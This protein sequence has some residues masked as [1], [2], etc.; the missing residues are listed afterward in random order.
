MDAE[1]L[2]QAELNTV[3][4]E[5]GGRGGLRALGPRALA[6]LFVG[7]SAGV[8]LAVLALRNLYDDELLTLYLSRS[9]V[10]EI[11][12]VAG[13]GDVHPP[14]MYL[15][16]HVGWLLT[17]S[18]RW[19]N[20]VPMAVL[21]AGLAVF[22]VSVAPLFRS[23]SERV[24]LLLLATLHPEL[25]MWSNTFRWYCPWTGLALIALTVAL[26][27][28]KESPVITPARA[29]LLGFLMGALFYLNYITLLFGL[30]LIAAALRRCRAGGRKVLARALAIAGAVFAALILPQLRT[31]LMVHLASGHA[32]HYGLA[33]SFVR[34]LQ[35][36]GESEAFLPWHPLA[37]AAFAALGALCVSGVAVLFRR[38][39]ASLSE[40][41]EERRSVAALAVFGIAYFV[42]LALAGLGGKPRSGLLLVPLLALIVA[43]ALERLGRR[44]HVSVL[45]LLGLWAIVGS[46]HLLGR[47]SALKT[48]M[49]DRPEEVVAFVTRS[50]REQPP[51]PS[52]ASTCGVVVVYDSGLAF[53]LAQ[54]TIPG[55]RIVSAFGGEIFTGSMEDRPEDCPR[56][57]LFV[58]ESYIDGVPMY[59][60]A[61]TRELHAA[62][63]F[64]RAPKI[65]RLNRDGDA[66]GK[67]RLAQ[68]L[69]S[70]S[71]A[72]LPDFRYVVVWGAMN[73]ASY[74]TMVDAL[75]DFHGVKR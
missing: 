71:G 15:L 54:A 12:G 14:G 25:L 63:S 9:S 22:L 28:G 43:A 69:R 47:H 38:R 52:G 64:I 74:R 51:A 5:R 16:A 65:E 37:V 53:R 41:S 72:R 58:V 42:F 70:G 26:Q 73:P 33:V 1:A 45:L 18:Y 57:L 8:S 17:H 61:Y 10:R 6:A 67:R 4:G 75:P 66:E 24:C 50:L 49:N 62:E 68:L 35:A 23:R 59:V 36:L 11:V 32:Q 29:V 44:A 7:L 34:L 30:A 21:Y 46:A 48:G 2:P 55:L 27:P 20:L 3:P 39:D 31:M 40:E 13:E 19:L 56:P 60:D